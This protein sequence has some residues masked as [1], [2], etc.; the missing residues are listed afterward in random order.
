MDHVVGSCWIGDFKKEKVKK[1]LGISEKWKVAA[2]VSSGYPAEKPQPRRKKP[3]EKI[4][5]FNKFYRSLYSGQ[6]NE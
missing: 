5:S 2:L 6:I 3:V 4:V 1:L